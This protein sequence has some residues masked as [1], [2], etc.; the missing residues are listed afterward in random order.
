MPVEHVENTLPSL[1]RLKVD[2]W[3]R[4]LQPLA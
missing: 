2:F 1:D 4:G 3:M